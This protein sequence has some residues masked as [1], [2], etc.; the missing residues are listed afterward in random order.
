VATVWI[1]L[2]ADLT[3]ANTADNELA[4]ALMR[5]V[6]LET[7]FILGDRHYNAPNVREACDHTGRI[8]VTTHYGP[9]PHTDSGVEVRRIFHKLRSIATENL[10]EHFK[11]IIDSR[12]QVP[13]KGWSTP[14]GL[15]WGQFWSINLHC[16][17]V[18]RRVLT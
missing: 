15:L 10:N 14:A 17:T 13:T 4:P 1:P 7:R 11:G 3:P 5:E 8:L 9:Y 2:A 18:S 6:P 12:G 16:F